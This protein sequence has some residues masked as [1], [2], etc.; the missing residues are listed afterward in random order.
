M[1]CK[2][3]QDGGRGRKQAKQVRG[4]NSNCIPPVKLLPIHAA[5]DTDVVSVA[6]L[7]MFVLVVMI[8]IAAVAALV[9]VL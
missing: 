3:R 4:S 7:R 8:P 1:A 2:H 5:T 6:V 9:C